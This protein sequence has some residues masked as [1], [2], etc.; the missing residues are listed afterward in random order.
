ME[1]ASNKAI[2][3]A[4]RGVGEG[5][6]AANVWIMVDN[7]EASM[8]GERYASRRLRFRHKPLLGWGLV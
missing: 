2:T 1:M 6:A 5:L 3:T 7:V 8:S 4:V